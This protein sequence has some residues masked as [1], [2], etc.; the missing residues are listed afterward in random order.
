[1][2]DDA[3][4]LRDLYGATREIG[5]TD[6][7]DRLLDEVLERAQDLIGFEHCAF[8]LY[9]P[10]ARSL[11]VERLRGYGDRASDLLGMS[12]PKGVGLS[13]VAAAEGR[14]VRVGDVRRDDRYVEGL[15]TARSNLAVPMVAGGELAGVINA[16]SERRDAFTETHEQLLTVLGAQ[17]ALAILASRARERLRGRIRQLDGLYRISRLAS[18]HRNLDE[19]LRGILQ[20]ARDVVPEGRVAILLRDPESGNLR[21]RAAEGYS[22]SVMQLEIPMREGIT[23]RCATQGRAVVVDDVTED[24]DYIPG[25]EGGRSEIAVPLRAEGEVIG[26]LDA[27]AT[28]PSAY[29]PEEKQTLAV[30]AQQVAA[31]VQT[32]QLYEQTREMA[33]TDSLTGLHNR[34]HFLSRLEHHLDRA[35]RYEERLALLLLDADDL[36][37]INDRH[38][39]VSGDRALERIAS[40]L[41]GCLRTSDEVARIGGDEFAAL[42][43]AADEDRALRVARRIQSGL[44]DL[45]LRTDDGTRVGLSV[46]IG[47]AFWPDD[48]RDGRLLFQRADEALYAAKNQGRSR[49]VRTEPPPEGESEPDPEG[50]DRNLLD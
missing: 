15:P 36:K 16:E 35:D 33:I 39:H 18:E 29:G 27:E 7:L 37:E 13:G 38:G 24:A 12:L 22:E 6:N 47:M 1:M 4:P 26:V 32:V 45:H 49:V 43:L 23:G 5:L 44:R 8:M 17:A 50:P 14:A 28:R 48:T 30:I 20:V 34:R 41:K 46:S 21:V 19:T 9:E 2:T 40:F 25:V 3:N 11:T 31:V 10:E 42:L